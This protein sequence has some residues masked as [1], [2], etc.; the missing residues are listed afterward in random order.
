MAKVLIT[1]GTGLVGM[2]LSELLTS[3]GI[4]VNHLSRR[5]T[6]DEVYPTY[7]WDLAAGTIDPKAFEGVD[8]IVHLA[9]APISDEKWTAER[10]QEILDSRIKSASLLQSKCEELNIKLKQFISASAIGWY[11]LIL[12]ED[13][14]SEASEIGTGFLADVCKEWEEAADRFEGIADKIVKLRIGLVLTKNA[15]ALT[16]NSRPI[17]FYLGA[18]LGSGKQYMSWIHLSDVARIFEHTIQ[19]NLS[20]VYNAVGPEPTNNQE[21]MQTLADVM[22]KPILLPNAPEFVIR[23]LFGPAAELVL[24]GVPLSSKKIRDTGFEFLYP[25]LNSSLFDIYWSKHI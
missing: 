16:Q 15:G 17:R 4:E 14:H 19:Q 13:V 20:G 6:G 11:P 7:L 9:G 1:G 18:G 5:L 24:R 10:K 2:A 12:S 22:D 3:S 8:R 21:F 25:T 23:L